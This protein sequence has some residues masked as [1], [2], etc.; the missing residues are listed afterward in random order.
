MGLAPPLPETAPQRGRSWSALL[1]P[2]HLVLSRRSKTG[3][4]KLLLLRHAEVHDCLGLHRHAG[5]T[6]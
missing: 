3:G 1:L 6:R 5:Q 2:G 4:A